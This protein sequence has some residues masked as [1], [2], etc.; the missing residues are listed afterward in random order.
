MRMRLATLAA[1]GLFLG[2]T[3][4]RAWSQHEGHGGM[5]DMGGMSMSDREADARREAES[6]RNKL[7]K[8]QAKIDA[9]EAQLEDPTLP[10]KKRVSLDK[11]LKKL[12][13]KKDRL[14]A[15]GRGEATAT[16]P[17]A[18]K[19]A[20]ESSCSQGADCGGEKQVTYVCPM[21][22]YSGPLTKDGRCPKCG[23]TLQKQ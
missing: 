5:G 19:K 11:K 16:A 10:T 14:L 8:L 13:E 2:P 21:G 18:K 17:V 22:H 23:M 4:G 6:R 9:L 1:L 12:Y 20:A 15:E 3:V 7:T